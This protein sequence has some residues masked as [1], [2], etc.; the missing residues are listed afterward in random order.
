MIRAHVA[1]AAAARWAFLVLSAVTA[2]SVTA[3]AEVGP[4][5]DSAATVASERVAICH[6]SE[7][8]P[9][10]MATMTVEPNPIDAHLQRGDRLGACAD[11]DLAGRHDHFIA[12]CG[13]A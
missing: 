6:V 4:A 11:D 7:N 8:D 9:T 12:A 10:A 13:G 1:R 3:C 2:V 5:D